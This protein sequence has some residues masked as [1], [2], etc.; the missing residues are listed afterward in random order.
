MSTRQNWAYALEGLQRQRALAALEARRLELARLRAERAAA[1]HRE[2]ASIANEYEQLKRG[3]LLETGRSSL[4]TGANLVSLETRAQAIGVALESLDARLQVSKAEL[5]LAEEEF[6]ELVR[7]L[8]GIQELAAQMEAELAL[9]SAAL[10]S[11]TRRPWLVGMYWWQW[12]PDP[13]IGGPQD[14]DYS[15]HRKPAEAVLR[16]W[17]SRTL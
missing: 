15:P 7:R 6:Q 11:L 9:A 17:Y 10:S 1:F 4:E 5:T 2:C 12:E 8:R 16:A 13:P 3:G 14:P